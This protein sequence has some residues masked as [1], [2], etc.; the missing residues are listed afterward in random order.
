MYIISPQEGRRF[1]KGLEYNDA[2]FDVGTYVQSVFNIYWTRFDSYVLLHP[3]KIHDKILYPNNKSQ[4]FRKK[5]RHK[6][7]KQMYNVI[8]REVFQKIHPF[9]SLSNIGRNTHR[10]LS[11]H[12]GD[13]KRTAKVAKVAW[14]DDRRELENVNEGSCDGILLI[15]IHEYQKNLGCI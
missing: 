12:L 1:G 2:T 14:R 10:Y 8:F 3:L 11:S 4:C 6:F 7:P 15:Y 5:M 9:S 13:K